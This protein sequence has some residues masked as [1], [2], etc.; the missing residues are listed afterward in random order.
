[1]YYYN[2][3]NTIILY[4]YICIYICIFLWVKYL[5]YIL[6]P[7]TVRSHIHIYYHAISDIKVTFHHTGIN[8]L[9][10]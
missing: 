5:S 3:C 7:H 6:S 1:M 10:F 4:I 2:N 9:A 8:I